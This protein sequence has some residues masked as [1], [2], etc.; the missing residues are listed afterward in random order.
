METKLYDHSTE[1]LVKL[2]RRLCIALFTLL[3]VLAVMWQF[4]FGEEAENESTA[5]TTAV[6]E[7]AEELPVYNAD[8]PKEEEL[9]SVGNRLSY[10]CTM[11]KNGE[12]TSEYAQGSGSSYVVIGTADGISASYSVSEEL[13]L[14]QGSEYKTV[15]KNVYSGSGK[16]VYYDGNLFLMP[17]DASGKYI[18][19]FGSGDAG[20][21]IKNVW[22]TE[23][24]G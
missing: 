21:I 13:P 10:V 24:S 6:Y 18:G 19:V 12:E 7:T 2:L 14:S 4:G 11:T 15:G 9:R 16:I 20:Q 5:E 8:S 1:Q 17:L 22:L 23:I 3:I